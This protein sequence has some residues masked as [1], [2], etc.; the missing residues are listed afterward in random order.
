MT[1]KVNLVKIYVL[2]NKSNDK[3]KI[4][5]NNHL[6]RNIRVNHK[7]HKVITQIVP[8]DLNSVEIWIPNI[9]KW[10]K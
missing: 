9:S 7:V 5:R 1:F 3:N 4:I 2:S 6:M 8:C 10:V